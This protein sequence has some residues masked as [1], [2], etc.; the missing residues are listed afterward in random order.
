MPPRNIAQQHKRLL[1]VFQRLRD[2]SL[3]LACSGSGTQLGNGGWQIR[4]I[5]CGH[6]NAGQHG[7]ETI[8]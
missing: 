6:R 3:R 4:A 5:G 2:T 7:D 1:A 8:A